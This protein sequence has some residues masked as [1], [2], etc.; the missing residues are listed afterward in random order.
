M[1]QQGKIRAAI[2]G[3]GN[4]GADILIKLQRSQTINCV[5]FAGR[6]TESAGINLAKS[7]QVPTTTNGFAG[8]HENADAFDLVFDATSAETHKKHASL[9]TKMGK[10]V[11][12]LTP[13]KIGRLCIPALNLS[14]IVEE[15]NINMITCGGQAATPIAH[16]LGTVHRDIEYIEVI[17]SIAAKSAGNATRWNIDEYLETTEMAIKQFSAC[18]H[19]KVILNINPA[20]PSV[21]MKTTLLA[22]IDNP[23]MEK[24]NGVIIDAVR[25]I[26]KYVPGYELLVEP[27]YDGKQVMV[28][29]S[30]MGNGDY[31]PK[32]AGNLDIITCA[33][34]KAGEAIAKHKSLNL[35]ST[36][37]TLESF[38]RM[39]ESKL[40]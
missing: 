30:V 21:M 28:M 38:P 18:R 2:I 40:K 19:A 15:N 12:D 17:S 11:I 24:I 6:N 23:D 27:R 14:E 22:K 29:V 13:A 39:R 25:N 36:V 1:I 5:L 31:L 20:V 37:K 34:V 35:D 8:L 10:R 3:T 4:I 9:L 26:K 32:F 16:A 7:L 33:A